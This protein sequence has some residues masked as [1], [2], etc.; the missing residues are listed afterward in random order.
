MMYVEIWG[1]RNMGD[2]S[3][4]SRKSKMEWNAFDQKCRET[5]DESTID[6]PVYYNT[7]QLYWVYNFLGSITKNMFPHG[8]FSL[9][10]QLP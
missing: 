3:E 9:V 7:T 8:V 2:V 10:M 1:Y 6:F 5:G 4:I